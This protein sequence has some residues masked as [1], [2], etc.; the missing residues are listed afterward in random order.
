MMTL[1]TNITMVTFVIK[2]T[3]VPVD[4]QELNLLLQCG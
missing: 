1:V 4:V 3:I 2:D